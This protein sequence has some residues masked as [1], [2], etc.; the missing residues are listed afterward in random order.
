M[1]EGRPG[2]GAMASWDPAWERVFREQEWGKYPPEHV[3]RFVARSFY[4]ASDRRAVRLLDLGSGPGAC[5]WFMAREGFSVSAID[6]SPTAVARLQARLGG[7]GLAADARVGD[8]VT[9]PWPDAT[10]DGV[11]DNGALCGNRFEACRAAV[12]EVRRVLRPGGAF[13]S[14]NLTDRSWGHGLGR[15]V[16]P[17]GFTDIREGPL[18]GKGFNLFMSRAQVDALYAPLADTVVERTG[19]TTDGMAHLVE[20]W[21]VTCRKRA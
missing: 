9:L 7:E 18:A 11:V 8:F 17:N 12:E 14:A 1:E 16:E 20:F 19:W 15:E 4:G 2:T 13:L 21:V 5:T 6:G 10:F 3:I